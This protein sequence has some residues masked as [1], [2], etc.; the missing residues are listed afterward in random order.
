MGLINRSSEFFQLQ[1]ELESGTFRKVPGV[2]N[3]SEVDASAPQREEAAFEGTSQRLGFLSV[4]TL[5]M[6]ASY[7]P[8]HDVWKKLTKAA[9]KKID[10]RYYVLTKGEEVLPSVSTRTVSIAANGQI[11]FGND[12]PDL[13]TLF[14]GEVLN[15]GSMDYV[16]DTVDPDDGSDGK[17]FERV[18]RRTSNKT[19]PST[20]ISSRTVDDS[21][22]SGW[23]D[24]PLGF[25]ISLPFEWVS[26]RTGTPGNW[27]PWGTPVL[28]IGDRVIV[29]NEDGTPPSVVS[30]GNYSLRIAA[31]RR[32]PFRAS[33]QLIGSVSLESEGNLHTDFSL[34][35]RHH[36]PDWAIA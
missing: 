18:F 28:W 24:D 3:Y 2:S 13:S 9:K 8:I 7:F 6:S 32:G 16:V 23:T 31:L 27:L 1:V 17:G 21:I 5:E 22:P 14:P 35:P 29:R 12:P 10:Y 33:I 34:S 11:T 19:A 15:I 4:P 36:L 26:K 30:G 25:D 20:P